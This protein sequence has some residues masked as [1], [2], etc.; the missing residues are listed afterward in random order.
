MGVGHLKPSNGR[1]ILDS[2]QVVSTPRTCRT[3]TRSTATKPRSARSA[4]ELTGAGMTLPSRLL[5]PHAERGMPV[6]KNSQS[7]RLVGWWTAHVVLGHMSCDPLRLR[8]IQPD[9]LDRPM[10]QMQYSHVEHLR[11]FMAISSFVIRV[12]GPGPRSAQECV[13]C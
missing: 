7:Y 3:S 1:L 12:F 9:Q 6:W 10:G 13:A 2:N 4:P 11:A 8:S 5:R